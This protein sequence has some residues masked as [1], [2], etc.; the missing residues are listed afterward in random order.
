MKFQY[1]AIVISNMIF[2]H[3]FS[4]EGV[5]TVRGA[6]A[7][8]R[9]VQVGAHGRSMDGLHSEVGVVRRVAVGAHGRVVVMVRGHGVARGVLSNQGDAVRIART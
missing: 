5:A 1:D 8:V 9:R 2:F 7:V 6:V 4:D 3:N